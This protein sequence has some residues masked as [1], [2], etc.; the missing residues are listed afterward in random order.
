MNIN[1]LTKKINDLEVDLNNKIDEIKKLKNKNKVLTDQLLEVNLSLNHAEKKIE[2]HLP[3]KVCSKIENY[4]YNILSP[5]SR[6]QVD[7]ELG[8]KKKFKIDVY[9]S[10]INEEYPKYFTK[11]KNEGI[12]YTNFLYYIN[13][14]RLK[15]NE[16]C[17]DNT[18]QFR[19]L[20]IYIYIF[21][22]FIFKY[23]ILFN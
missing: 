10:K 18:N 2:N 3:Q 14:F 19:S 13:T 20:Y 21:H 12:D 7:K 16:E 11:I 22:N 9:I 4:F 5:T 6:Q 17:H 23:I 8:D 15:N 1:D